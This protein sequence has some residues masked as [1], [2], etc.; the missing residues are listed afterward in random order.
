[1]KLSLTSPVLLGLAISA[2]PPLHRRKET[3]A[4]PARVEALFCFAALAL[5]PGRRPHSSGTPA[6]AIRP[7]PLQG[8][9]S[10]GV[11]SRRTG[12]VVSERHG[13]QVV[14]HPRTASSVHMPEQGPGWRDP[15]ANHQRQLLHHAAAAG[16]DGIGELLILFT[17]SS[18]ST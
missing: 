5:F 14:R 16:H 11:A 17:Q 3:A 4:G 2:P 1:P 9:Q 15:P 10:G 12:T 6:P 8:K 7:H 13:G 18:S